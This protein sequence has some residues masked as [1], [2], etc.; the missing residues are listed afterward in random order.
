MTYMDEWEYLYML[1][2]EKEQKKKQNSPEFISEK[3]ETDG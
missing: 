1:E 3:E 2:K